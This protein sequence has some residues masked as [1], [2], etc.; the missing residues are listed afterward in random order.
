MTT[1]CK[2]GANHT[3]GATGPVPGISQVNVRRHK[4]PVTGV[5]CIFYCP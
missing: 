3:E 2:A 5:L 4:I 1:L